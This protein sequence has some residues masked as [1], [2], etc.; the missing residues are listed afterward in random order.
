MR[1]VIAVPVLL[2]LAGCHVIQE[3]GYPAEFIAERGPTHVW[4]TMSDQSQHELFNPTM[5]G[6]T[7]Q[8]F[9]G[10]DFFE[11]PIKDVRI[12]RASFIAPGRTALVVGAGLIVTAIGV[13]Y[14]LRN[15]SGPNNVCYSAGT[16]QIE[17][18]VYNQPNGGGVIVADWTP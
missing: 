10:G 12:M 11:A 13:S 14:G 17:P 3:V 7:I 16:A 4:V 2:A 1:A 9:T 18:C 6:D 8:G 5:N 15:T